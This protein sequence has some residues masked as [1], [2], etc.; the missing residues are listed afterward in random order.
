M[1]TS[2]MVFIVAEEVCKKRIQ[3]LYLKLV[4]K[5]LMREKLHKFQIKKL[6]QNKDQYYKSP[7]LHNRKRLETS[8]EAS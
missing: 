6:F 5:L 1:A 7:S 4:S 2:K 8:W 3:K